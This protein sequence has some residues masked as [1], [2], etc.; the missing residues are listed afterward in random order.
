MA[1]LPTF[2]ST[3]RGLIAPVAL[4]TAIGVAVI[5]TIIVFAAREL[6]RVVRDNSAHIL[7]SALTQTREH[8]KTVAFD[9]SYW[10]QAVENLVENLDPNWADANVGTY[11]RETQGICSTY[12]LNPENRAVYSIARCKTETDDPFLRFEG[13]LK[14]LANEARKS[15]RNQK[16][17]AVE[18]LFWDGQFAHTLAA[19][20][21]TDYNIVDGKEVP[22]GTDWV[23][24]V[25]IAFNEETV[26]K[27][28]KEFLLPNLR[29]V[30]DEDIGTQVH[31]PITLVDGKQPA[32]FVWDPPKPGQEMLRRTTP[33]V[34]AVFFVVGGLTVLFVRR[35]NA[36]ARLLEKQTAAVIEEKARVANYLDVA[37]IILVALDDQGNITL[38]NRKG[39]EVLGYSEDELIGQNW[40]E[41]VLPANE[42]REKN[43]A[44]RKVFAGENEPI[45]RRESHV[46]TKSGDRRLI[47]WQNS[48]VRGPDGEI[49]SSLGSG[50]DIT[51]IRQAEEA[52]QEK[53]AHL[54]AVLQNSSTEIYVK[55]IDG[56]F[57]LVNEKFASDNGVAPEEVVGKTS[58]D[59]MSKEY[60][61]AFEAYSRSVIESKSATTFEFQVSRADGSQPIYFVTLFPIMGEDGDVIGTGGISTDITERA[62]TEAT[63]KRLQA[64]LANILRVGT[65]GEMATGIAHEVNQ[66]LA[67]IKNYAMGML[68]RLRSGGAKPEDM[69]R[70]LEIIGDQAQR[71][72]DTIRNIRQ[73]ARRESGEIEEIDVNAAIRDVV[74]V[75]TN[76]AVAGNIRIE[77]DLEVDLP[78]P[79]GEAVQIQQAVLNL[80]RN[81]MDAMAE[82]EPDRTARLLS[83]RTASTDGDAVEISVVDTGPGIPEGLR[84]QIFH[85][86]FTTRPAGLGMGLPICRTIVEA[87]GGDIWFTRN[88]DKGTAFHFTLPVKTEVPE[89]PL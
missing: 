35:A 25:S 54:Q 80:A 27:I 38:I 53:S 40:F 12:V 36:T 70:I 7:Q 43:V 9:N 42:S 67:A 84:A 17:V 13:G 59:M 58:H 62:Q 86:F 76:E 83:L 14:K 4:S 1:A 5:G 71:A 6:D 49:I 23:L 60:S 48:F 79:A 72:G 78:R 77:L 41:R 68:R 37:E 34:L 87:H 47:W 39:C 45:L 30:P 16:P 29:V 55:D 69:T 63:A 15:P 89:S 24:I 20:V 31:Q 33:F 50:Q 73:I 32:S 81:A 18:G 22:E 66:P 56:R 19:S 57:L 44:F 64:D 52:L 10:D 3:I 82:I 11:L 28:S 65:V 74:S 46:L 21:L 75:L 88:P 26:A 2:R 8:V 61:D 85:P 51:E